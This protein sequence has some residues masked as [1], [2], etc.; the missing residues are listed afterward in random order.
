MNHTPRKQTLCPREIHMV[1]WTNAMY[2]PDE[3]NELENVVR[4][5]M[6]QRENDVLLSKKLFNIVDIA[7]PESFR[8]VADRFGLSKGVTWKIFKEMI[9]ILKRWLP[10]F[11]R[12][13]NDAECKESERIFEIRSRGFPGVVG[14]I[15]GCH[16]AI[17]QP[18][19]NANDY[20]NRK[21]FHS[22][23]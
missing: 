10:H 16:I 9:W 13:S 3:F 20:Y 12:W 14:V 8:S 19:R 11:I 4:P 15:D 17:K 2:V 22:I 1:L 6:R 18:L 21:E 23:I 5:L 7:T